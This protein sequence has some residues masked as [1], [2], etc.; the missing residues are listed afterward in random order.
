V[1][2]STSLQEINRLDDSFR[3]AAMVRATQGQCVICLEKVE[4]VEGAKSGFWFAFECKDP[5]CGESAEPP[6]RPGPA[7]RAH[8]PR[9]LRRFSD[10][11]RRHGAHLCHDC[12][13]ALA[14]TD[15]CLLH[16]DSLLTPP[17]IPC[18]KIATSL[19]QYLQGQV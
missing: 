16:I 10:D 6:Q 1:V 14:S 17:S 9:H 3:S 13:N 12:R 5:T 2:G 18:S 8:D 4:E 11:G 7:R 15:D 19:L